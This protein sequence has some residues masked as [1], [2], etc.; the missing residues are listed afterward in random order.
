MDTTNKAPK[1]PA[2]DPDQKPANGVSRKGKRPAKEFKHFESR[3][4]EDVLADE[5]KGLRRLF[6]GARNGKIR[7]TG[8]TSDAS[9]EVS[10][11]GYATL[12]TRMGT[13]VLRI[14]ETD[15][16][17]EKRRSAALAYLEPLPGTVVQ[18]ANGADEFDADEFESEFQD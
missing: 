11:V 17:S 4:L 3:T 16:A 1:I 9:F 18:N 2:T 7:Y 6:T 13:R 10:N 14:S 15:M 8:S 12:E 5:S